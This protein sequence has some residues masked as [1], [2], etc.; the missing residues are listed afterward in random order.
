MDICRKYGVVL[1]AALPFKINTLMYA[2][3]ENQI[4]AAA[5]QRRA[6][7]YFNL[8]KNYPQWRSWLASHGPLLVALNVDATWDNATATNGLLDA[9]KPNTVRGGHAVCVVGYRK[10][11]RFIIRNSWGT[12][13]GDKGF[14]YATEAYITGAFFDESYGVTV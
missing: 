12:T 7:S 6:T 14:G 8:R 9:F 3:D 1:D 5:A 4:F 13:W 2:G 11:G 10:D